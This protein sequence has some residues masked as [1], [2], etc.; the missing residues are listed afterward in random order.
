MSFGITL[1]Q[2]YYSYVECVADGG[3]RMCG[4]VVKLF[5]A[6]EELLQEDYWRYAGHRRKEKT[7]TNRHRC[8]LEDKI[9]GK[10]KNC[11]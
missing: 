7:H 8:V 1:G 11:Q 2:C 9:Q 6:K 3:E 10:A 4:K 5:H